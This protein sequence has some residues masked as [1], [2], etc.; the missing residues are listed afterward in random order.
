VRRPHACTRSGSEGTAD[1][2]VR[3]REPRS[4]AQRC[5]DI[6]TQKFWN[7]GLTSLQTVPSDQRSC[8]LVENVT[9]TVAVTV[10]AIVDVSYMP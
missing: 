10:F 7:D 8:Q 2:V 3:V 9:D 1:R 4:H 5:C 6:C